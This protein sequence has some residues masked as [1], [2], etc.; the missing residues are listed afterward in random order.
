MTLPTQ[1]LIKFFDLCLYFFSYLV[2]LDW[3]TKHAYEFLIMLHYYQILHSVINKCKWTVCS[4]WW[5]FQR[6]ET[7]SLLFCLMRK[8][9][10]GYLKYPFTSDFLVPLGCRSKNLKNDFCT[11][12]HTFALAEEWGSFIPEQDK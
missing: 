10:I 11:T 7:F 4:W 2:T 1:D 6:I 5:T 9:S 3:P 8:T 12:Q